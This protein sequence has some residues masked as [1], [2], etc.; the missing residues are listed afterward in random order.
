MEKIEP[1]Q[2]DKEFGRQEKYHCLWGKCDDCTIVEGDKGI[3]VVNRMNVWK[4]TQKEKCSCCGG[5]GDVEEECEECN[6]TGKII[7]DC[8]DCD[9][10]GEVWAEDGDKEL[11]R[12][13]VIPVE[14]KMVLGR[15]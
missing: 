13:D 11:L 15:S 10:E 6:G 14:K 5:Q 2:I 8:D 7:E 4:L 1:G 12:Q 9:G 3:H